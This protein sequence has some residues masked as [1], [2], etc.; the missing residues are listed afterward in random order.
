M[1]EEAEYVTRADIGSS[2]SGMYWSPMQEYLLGA[3]KTDSEPAD[4]SEQSQP[5]VNKMSEEGSRAPNKNKSEEN[6]KQPSKEPS[7]AS[8]T[9]I[10]REKTHVVDEPKSVQGK[11]MALDKRHSM[12]AA[13][14]SF[15][16]RV[17]KIED[18]NQNLLNDNKHLID[19]LRRMNDESL[20]IQE[21]IKLTEDNLQKAMTEN[22]LYK[23][24]NLDLSNQVQTLKTDN[25]RLRK[26][27]HDANT[28]LKVQASE[29]ER[30]RDNCD[31]K[32]EDA[33]SMIKS[34]E[35][36][37]E[38]LTET[39][40]QLEN[41]RSAQENKT[42]EDERGLEAKV[43]S[44]ESLNIQLQERNEQLQVDLDEAENENETLLQNIQNLKEKNK[45]IETLK[46]QQ[47]AS[48]DLQMTLQSK[49]ELCETLEQENLSLTEQVSQRQSQ[50]DSLQTR[51][52][53][54]ESKLK[55]QEIELRSV[56]DERDS[57]EDKLI[58]KDSE[59]CKNCDNLE[60]E[61]RRLARK[62]A[63][64]KEWL[65]TL[66]L[67][68]ASLTDISKQKQDYIE[69]LQKEVVDLRIQNTSLLNE[70]SNL[71]EAKTAREIADLQM[72]ELKSS[73]KRV[74]Q[75]NR[76]LKNINVKTNMGETNVKI[77]NE[78]LKSKYAAVKEKLDVANKRIKKL[79]ML[80][81]EIY[82]NEEFQQFMQTDS[83]STNSSVSL[84][85]INISNTPRYLNTVRR[86]YDTPR[87]ERAFVTPRTERMGQPHIKRYKIADLGKLK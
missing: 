65:D 40:K 41:K 30:D 86:S 28:L 69:R 21:R 68:G 83:Q 23:T 36:Q 2:E 5:A 59:V 3:N 85:D 84:P 6:T 49:E 75:E 20:E 24:E 22:N 16:G 9:T 72:E 18:D 44:L 39:N 51:M 42:V 34:L 25:D 73:Y 32:L 43:T 14:K 78:E 27:V 31:K 77:E 48:S 64:Q 67:S 11:Q 15:L 82:T 7:N 45:E 29:F 55:E 62:N 66:R 61:L 47:E 57:L 81:D 74:V 63:D 1:Y 54:M 52:L 70:V 4:N 60:K 37:V 26:A 38:T 76:G 56:E 46:A 17:D 71:K 13:A 80:I 87:T 19:N 53:E 50:I 35:G 10:V 33:Y 8:R 12:E 79:E 58:K